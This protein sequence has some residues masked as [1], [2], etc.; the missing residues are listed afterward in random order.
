[1]TDHLGNQLD[2]TKM[3]WDEKSR[4]YWLEFENNPEGIEVRLKW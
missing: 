2:S 4:T 1:M 3:Q